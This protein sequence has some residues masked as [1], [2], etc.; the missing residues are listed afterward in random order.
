MFSRKFLLIQTLSCWLPV[1]SLVA[2]FGETKPGCQAR[3]G[4][5]SIPY[6]FGITV[7]GD[8]DNRGAGGCSIHGVGYGYNVNCNTSYD[9]P[10]AFIGRG[11]LEILSISETEIRQKSVDQTE[12]NTLVLG[13][14]GYLD[15][16]YF[17]TSQLT[18]KSDVYSYGVVL[19]ELLTGK[20]PISMERSEEQ[21]NIA[22]YFLSSMENTNLFPLL[23]A[24]VVNEGTPEQVVELAELAKKC[25]NM[26]GEERPTMRQVTTELASFRMAETRASASEPNHVRRTALP[27][28]PGDLYAVPVYSS[29]NVDSGQ[30]SFGADTIASMNTP[31]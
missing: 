31:R 10:K 6:P 2:A 25:L 18:E 19:V 1:V 17:N 7:G 21:G 14:L 11:K 4:N 28:E 22:S 13:T 5:I 8:D 15:P 9:P 29:T 3:C 23:D 30:Y 16:E 12:L 24:R 26:N 27:T 20:K